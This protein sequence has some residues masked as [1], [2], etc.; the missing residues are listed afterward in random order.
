MPAA[1]AQEKELMIYCGITMV[2]PI[3]ELARQ[4]EQHEKVKVTI[5]QGGSEDLYQSAKKAASATFIFPANPPTAIFT[6]P[7][8][9]SA[10]TSWS[11]TT[12][13]PCSWP[14][15]TPRGSSRSSMKSSARI[16]T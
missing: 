14:R 8:D 12:R 5:A 15:A 10:T 4:F 6:R 11:A 3:T 7:K 2:R 16:S 13:W 1:H 9:C